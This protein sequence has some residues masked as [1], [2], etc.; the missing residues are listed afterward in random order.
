MENIVAKS[1]EIVQLVRYGPSSHAELLEFSFVFTYMAAFFWV[2]LSFAD[3][4]SAKRLRTSWIA[5]VM[6][7]GVSNVILGS[8][9]TLLLMWAWREEVMAK[10]F[11]LE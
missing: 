5:I 6:L 2:I 4:K 8:G 7:L 9:S 11:I 10:K 3:L 1:Y